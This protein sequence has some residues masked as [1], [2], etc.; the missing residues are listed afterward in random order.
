MV[1]H[2][3]L[4]SCNQYEALAPEKKEEYVS[5]AVK[6]LLRENFKRGLSAK[7]IETASYFHRNTISKHL[8]KLLSTREIYVNEDKKKGKIYHIN[9][10]IDHPSVQDSFLD[11]KSNRQYS[12]SLLENQFNKFIYVQEITKDAYSKDVVIGGILISPDSLDKL[13]KILIEIKSQIKEVSANTG[14]II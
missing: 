5:I 2:N 11:E 8:N 14:G 3:S 12:I 9:G 6:Q 10:N 1:L 13:V 7:E 4:I